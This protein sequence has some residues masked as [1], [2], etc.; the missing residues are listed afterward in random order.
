MT[1]DYEARNDSVKPEDLQV[2]MTLEHRR[3][4]MTTFKVEKIEGDAA[5]G[6]RYKTFQVKWCGYPIHLPVTELL[7]N[8]WFFRSD[9]WSSRMEE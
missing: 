8:S 3:W 5:Y 1:S 7:G 4:F 9:L 6:T 2:G